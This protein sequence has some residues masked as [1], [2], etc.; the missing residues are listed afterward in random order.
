MFAVKRRDEEILS[1]IPVLLTWRE[2]RIAVLFVLYV[3]NDLSNNSRILSRIFAFQHHRLVYIKPQYRI[4][5]YIVGLILGYL[6]SS[7]EATDKYKYTLKFICLGWIISL[8]LA[9][10]SLF[11][12]YPALQV[13]FLTELPYTRNR[14]RYVNYGH[15]GC[16]ISGLVQTFKDLAEIFPSNHHCVC[17]LWNEVRWARIEER[18]F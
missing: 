2:D 9:F 7:T 15:R 10:S 16:L 12:L 1:P 3:H 17:F 5:P 6:L 13:T 18:V 14:S 8:T 4:G 11:G